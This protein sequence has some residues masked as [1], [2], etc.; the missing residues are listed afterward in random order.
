MKEY[1]DFEIRFVAPD[2]ARSVIIVQ[3]PGGDADGVCILPTNDAA[4]Q[5]LLAALVVSRS[6]RR[7]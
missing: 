1:V 7:G 3:G 5:V 2:E 6:M 4:F